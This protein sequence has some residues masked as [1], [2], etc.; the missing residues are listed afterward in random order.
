MQRIN[1]LLSAAVVSLLIVVA[2]LLHALN[3]H[4]PYASQLNAEQQANGALKSEKNAKGE[5][6]TPTQTNE[7]RDGKHPEQRENKGTEF[8]PSFLGVRLKITDSLLAAFTFGLLIFTGLL[9]NSTEKLWKPFSV[10]FRRL[11]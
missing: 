5:A 7:E 6:Q 2:G 10:T 1:V 3:Q 9:W 8:W 11:C 4:P